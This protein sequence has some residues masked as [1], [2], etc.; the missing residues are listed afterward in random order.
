M[1]SVHRAPTVTKQ[2]NDFFVNVVTITNGTDTFTEAGAT[3][4]VA[5]LGSSGA[6]AN[7]GNLLVRD[8]GK[9]VTVASGTY[10]KVQTYTFAG[11][12]NGTLV[13]YTFYIKVLPSAGNACS[14]ARMTLQA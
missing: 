7:P 8:M 2:G 4:V 11:A 14:W 9:T 12:T 10:R 6:T 5:G 3:Y 1:S 13:D